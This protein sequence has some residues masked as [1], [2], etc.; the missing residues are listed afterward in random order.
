M[1]SG[2]KFE[3]DSDNSTAIAEEQN[4]QSFRTISGKAPDNIDTIR[5]FY[6]IRVICM[7]KKGEQQAVP[8]YKFWERLFFDD[9]FCG[10]ITIV[11][12]ELQHIQTI[13]KVAGVDRRFFPGFQFKGVL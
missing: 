5:C 2:S 8:L 1:F 11:A 7:Q 3:K 13:G 12:G 10:I 9:Q 6:N 4:Y